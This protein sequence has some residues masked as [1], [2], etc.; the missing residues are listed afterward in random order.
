MASIN[1][2][3]QSYND[4]LEKS[5]T[6]YSGILGLPIDGSRKV[7]VPNR[8][9]FVYV[10]LRDNLS[11]VVQAIN[12]KISPVYDFPVLME[13]KNNR[14]YI[15]GRDD[16]RYETWGTS[17]PFLPQ[18]GEQHS[19]NRDGGGGG[20][21][22]AVYPDQFMPLLVYPSGT[23]GGAG[24]LLIAPYMLEM[25]D[26][27][28]YVG[29][30]GT[31]NLLQYRPVTDE[32]IMGL[33][34]LNRDTGNPH[35]IIASGTPFAGTTTGSSA[36]SP[37]IPYPPQNIEPLYAFRLV[38]GTTTLDWPNLYNVRQ[39]FRGRGSTATGSSGGGISGI[40]A[41]DE[42]TPVGTGT[43]LNFVGSNVNVTVSGTVINVMVTGSSGG[44]LPTF[45]TGSIPYAGSDGALKE[46]N[47]FA[48][49]DEST[50]T[51]WAGPKPTA[52]LAYNDIR[53]FAVATGS[54]AS[55]SFGGISAGTGSLGSPSMSFNGYRSRGTFNSPTPVRAGDALLT[56]IGNGFDG[57]D[58]RNAGRFRFYADG[59]WI[60]G[61]HSPSRAEVEVT[62]SGS[63]TRVVG[64][65][66][67]ADSTNIPTGS[68]YNIGGVPHTHGDS[69][70]SGLPLG[71]KS[72][73]I[74]SNN[75][76]DA[77]NDIDIAVGKCRDS[78]D[79]DD[80]V[81]ASAITKR[82]DA[83]W[84]VGT[85]QGGLDTGSIA[86]TTYHVWIIKRSDTGVVDV[87]FSTSATAPTMPTD[88]DYKRRIGS[89]VRL[90]GAIKAFVQDGNHFSWATPV[91]DVN[92]VN[93]GTS[94][95]TRTLTLPTGIRIRADV[96]VA[97]TGVSAATDNPQGILISDLSTNDTT[98]SNILCTIFVYSTVPV[99]LAT[100][101]TVYTNTSAQIRSRV[102]V[103]T[104]NTVLYISTYGWTD[105]F[106]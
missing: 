59:N 44:S 60:T 61:S 2:S 35:I 78:T 106:D 28:V 64:L 97:G 15:T 96:S 1:Q 34:G 48:R 26:R 84:T 7:N 30:T 9:G 66:V 45:I 8:A 94:A 39:M 20:D 57:N 101:T 102:Q 58:W 21:P 10:R 13:R 65:T 55:V 100:V 62:P 5:K 52:N 93:P 37:Y 14:W 33:V 90:S 71:Y 19:F 4:S 31:V 103:S 74:L 40:V 46:F 79:A 22:V 87:L 82:L 16:G 99:R 67:Y 3:I 11:E 36:V 24:N 54:N 41:W 6:T 83:S 92:S 42:G 17:A 81:L 77:T 23:S 47:D 88:Y 12:D 80:I 51:I 50:Q 104:A 91:G 27:Y 95:V 85:N 105:F 53:F 72:G 25:S 73:L 76:T 18:H 56:I 89:I 86:N 32:A 29:N 43:V 38:S 68:T 69:G 49:F 70:A 63:V 98:P 75:T